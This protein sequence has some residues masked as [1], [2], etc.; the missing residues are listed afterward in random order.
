MA[1][2]W[3]IPQRADRPLRGERWFTNLSIVF[4][5]QLALRLLAFLM[6]LLAIGA[7]LDAGRGPNLAQRNS[8]KTRFCDVAP[9]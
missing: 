3:A 2:E 8:R 9:L 1:L 5:D 4:I 6:P 7:A